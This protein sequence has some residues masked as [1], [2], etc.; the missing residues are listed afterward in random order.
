METNFK[1]FREVLDYTRNNPPF[2]SSERERL[3][4][5]FRSL[6]LGD[7]YYAPSKY[8]YN[9]WL[10]DEDFELLRF[11]TSGPYV[12]SWCEAMS[13]ITQDIILPDGIIERCKL[14]CFLFSSLESLFGYYGLGVKG[15]YLLD[16]CYRVIFYQFMFNP[17]LP[18]PPKYFDKSNYT[19]RLLI[20]NCSIQE[21]E[22]LITEWLASLEVKDYLIFHL[23]KPE[24]PYQE[25][26]SIL[27]G[28][29][30]YK[31]YAEPSIWDGKYI[32]IQYD[33]GNLGVEDIKAILAEDRRNRCISSIVVND[34]EF[35][36]DGRDNMFKLNPNW[37]ITHKP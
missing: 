21:Q 3:M 32:D 4:D 23:N 18:A 15:G 16:Y 25:I 29:K 1:R 27:E 20:D 35:F 5:L 30:L 14:C 10:F 13:L 22:N 9:Q 11:P 24:F 6:Y 34:M 12:Y 28:G 26:T 37:L 17:L 36:L 8:P 31:V 2:Y 33:Q 19:P 7:I